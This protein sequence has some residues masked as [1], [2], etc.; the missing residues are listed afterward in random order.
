MWRLAHNPNGVNFDIEALVA[1]AR[2]FTGLEGH[3]PGQRGD[4][5]PIL[6]MERNAV[7]LARRLSHAHR[8][9][10]TQSCRHSTMAQNATFCA[11]S[12]LPDAM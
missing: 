3:G 5:R 12:P 1:A 9:P 6:S 11:A 4:L 8:G 7:G 2:G 10:E